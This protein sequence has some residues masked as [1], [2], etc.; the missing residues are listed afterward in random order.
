[1][2]SVGQ[3]LAC[4]GLQPVRLVVDMLRILLLGSGGN[5]PARVLAAV[6]SDHEIAAAL[7]PG[8]SALWRRAIR[9]VRQVR[10]PPDPFA[11]EARRRGIE[12]IH[13]ASKNDPRWEKLLARLRPDLICIASYPWLLP[14]SVFSMPRL[15]SINLH[16][17]LLPRRRG[18]SPF[19]WVYYHGDAVSGV[20][21]H[22]VTARAD[23][24]NILAQDQIPV[25]FGMTVDDLYE[26]SARLGACLM[27]RAVNELDRG[28]ALSKPQDESLATIDP[29]VKPGQPMVDF[30]SWSVDRVWHFLHGLYPRF[31]E[32]LR[33]P[34]GS[35]VRYSGVGHFEKGE[36]SGAPGS[37]KQ[38]KNGWLLNCRNGYIQ[39]IDK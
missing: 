3:A 35:L 31:Q 7:M 34:N 24:G 12:V 22:Q 33:D 19:F 4:V 21:I 13:I 8:P 25:P 28:T 29:R 38:S 1:L 23:Q 27:A 39:L 37:V 6:A 36:G 16:P 20:T 5:L 2:F 11:T 30:A 17:S 9:R 10:Q 32:P 15:G 18:P 14:P 26:E